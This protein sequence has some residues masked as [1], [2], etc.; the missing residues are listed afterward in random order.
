MPGLSLHT[1]LWDTGLLAQM[2]SPLED[3]TKEEGKHRLPSLPNSRRTAGRHSCG[4]G[5]PS[6]HGNPRKSSAA[7]MLT[8]S[9]SLGTPE[10]LVPKGCLSA[11]TAN[12]GPC[13]SSLCQSRNW[14]GHEG[15]EEGGGWIQRT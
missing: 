5:A 11:A 12:P 3:T 9:D 10:Q 15:V 2:P 1:L 14:N 4:Y 6:P 8:G 7:L 13:S